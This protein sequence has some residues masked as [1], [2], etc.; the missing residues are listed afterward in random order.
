MEIEIRK[1]LY[2]IQQAS[3]LI[4]DFIQGESFESYQV[5][6]HAEICR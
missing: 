1:Y 4:I 2:D 3:Q 5:Q 6:P